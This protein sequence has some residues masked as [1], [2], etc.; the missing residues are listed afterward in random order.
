MSCARRIARS[1]SRPLVASAR[2]LRATVW[3]TAPGQPRITRLDHG[4]VVDRLIDRVGE[5]GCEV[6]VITAETVNAAV[7]CRRITASAW[8]LPT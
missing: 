5:A 4:A 2:A 7:C 6:L 3:T 8:W 1:T